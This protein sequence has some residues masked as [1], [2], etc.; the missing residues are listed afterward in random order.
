MHKER[1]NEICFLLSE[2]IRKEI[3]EKLFDKQVI[4]VLRELGWKQSL[5]DFDIRLSYQMGSK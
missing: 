1:W 4:P 3:S 5:N 2:N